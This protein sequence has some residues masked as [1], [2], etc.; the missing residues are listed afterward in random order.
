[1]Y[2]CLHLQVY[3][4]GVLM[5]KWAQ[6]CSKTLHMWTAAKEDRESEQRCL[7]LAS[8]Y[9]AN[10]PWEPVKERAEPKRSKL[11]SLSAGRVTVSG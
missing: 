5:Q 2:P 11:E 7:P 4:P 6:L 9:P 8:F 10:V 3:E 1:M